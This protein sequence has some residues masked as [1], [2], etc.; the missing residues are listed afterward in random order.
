M[1]A[2]IFD[3]VFPSRSRDKSVVSS[4][5]DNTEG[6]RIQCL[7]HLCKLHVCRYSTSVWKGSAEKRY[8][9]GRMRA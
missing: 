1:I 8:N 2:S 7:F 6:R 5:V 9:A 4:V 3:A